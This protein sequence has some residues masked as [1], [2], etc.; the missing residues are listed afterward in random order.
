VYA[1]GA[2]VGA[3]VT[4]WSENASDASNNISVVYN[5]VAA[6]INKRI[7]G[8]SRFAVVLATLS[9]GA[10]PVKISLSSD[11][12]MKLSVNG[13]ESGLGLGTELY[14]DTGFDNAGSWALSGG[15]TVSGSKLNCP[16][17][18]AGAYARQGIATAGKIYQVSFDIEAISAGSLAVVASTAVYISPTKS[19]AGTIIGCGV[20]SNTLLGIRV[21]STTT[22]TIDTASAKEVYNNTDTT[23]IPWATVL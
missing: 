16:N 13:V 15:T 14:A 22:A 4:I 18:T 2:T 7:G 20:A 23:A 3:P 19:S 10:Y 17:I 6:Y 9:P 12:T 11:N 5:G 1:G 8:V 21:Q